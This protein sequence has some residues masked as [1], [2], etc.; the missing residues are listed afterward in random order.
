MSL[1][2]RRKMDYQNLYFEKN[3]LKTSM[4][5]QLYPAKPEPFAMSLA[6]FQCKPL[7]TVSRGFAFTVPR[8][9]QIEAQTLSKYSTLLAMTRQNLSPQTPPF[10]GSHECNCNIIREII[11]TNISRYTIRTPIACPCITIIML[12]VYNYMYI[13]R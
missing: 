9:G 6:E 1:R 3:Q 10:T 5:K 8:T 7:V 11:K 13:H 4:N 2:K 12:Y